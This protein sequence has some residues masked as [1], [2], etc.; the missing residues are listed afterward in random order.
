LLFRCGT[1]SEDT[2][3][4]SQQARAE[5]EPAQAKKD[6]G[7]LHPDFAFVIPP[8]DLVV[9]GDERDEQW[10]D[11]HEERGQPLNLPRTADRQ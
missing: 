3:D 8:P 5:H 11:R 1:R 6:A 2:P 4:E 7:H 10:R 9:L